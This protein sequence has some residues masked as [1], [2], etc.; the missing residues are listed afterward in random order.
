MSE[1]AISLLRDYIESSNNDHMPKSEALA[2]LARLQHGAVGPKV[3][4]M[5]WCIISAAGGVVRVSP[6]QLASLDKR[7]AV[8]RQPDHETGGI[9]FIATRE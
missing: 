4:G 3:I 1:N 8:V 9:A 6:L 5:L 7:C 2:A